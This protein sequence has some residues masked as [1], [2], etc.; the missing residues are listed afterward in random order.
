M[1]KALVVSGGG[2]K[3]AYAVGVLNYLK[4]NRPA[5]FSQGQFTFGSYWGTST[6]ALVVPLAAT[7]DLAMLNAF[8]S[9]QQTAGLLVMHD[10]LRLLQTGFLFNSAG[11]DGLID[12]VF[13][14]NRF[15]ILLAG[16]RQVGLAAVC[17]QTGELRVFSTRPLPANRPHYTTQQLTTRAD[18]IDA[19]RAS[20]HQPFFFQPVRFRS[21]AGPQPRHY[22]DGGVREYAPIQAALD[23]GATD[24]VAVLLSPAEPEAAPGLNPSNLIGVL[25]RTID[26]FTNDVG[27][28][29]VRVPDLLSRGAAYVQALRGRLSAAG[30]SPAQISAVL[31]PGNPFAGRPASQIHIIRPQTPLGGGPGGLRFEPAEM[32]A[33]VRRGEADAA[34]YFQ[35]VDQNSGVPPDVLV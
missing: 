22:V 7:G 34:A 18:L 35:R 30:L 10:A 3:G 5:Y 23:A 19:I 13:D 1:S 4:A 16:G 26:I 8:Y 6:G 31:D 2:S 29:D 9:G 12:R 11:L 28:N 20:V 14:A 33:M 15:A 21:D 25:E 27:L 24:V 32:Q 17:L